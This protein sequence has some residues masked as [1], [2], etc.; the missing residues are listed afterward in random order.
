VVVQAP[1]D[2]P[3][4]ANMVFTALEQAVVAF[5]GGTSAVVDQAAQTWRYYRVDVPAGVLGWDLRLREVSG[6]MPQMVVRRDLLP[7]SVRTQGS[8]NWQRY[9]GYNT[10]WP[11]GYQ[12]AAGSD[13]TG[14]TY[15]TGA[16]DF[17]RPGPRMLMA[18]GTPLEA[19]TYYVG[20][21]NPSASEGSS[22]VLDSRGVGLAGSGYTYAVEAEELALN[23]GAVTVSGVAPREAR[24]YRLT[25]PEN[26]PSVELELEVTSGEMLMAIRRGGIPDFGIREDGAPSSAEGE[27]YGFE[28]WV[29]KVGSERY[30]MLPG[31]GQTSITAGEYYVAVVGEGESPAGSV[32]GTGT[33]SGV[34]RSNGPLVVEDLGVATPGGLAHLVDL[35]AGQLKLFRFSV[36]EQTDSLEVRRETI[37]GSPVM[38]VQEGLAIPYTYLVEY[39]AEGGSGGSSVDPIFTQ[40]APQAGVWTVVVQAPKDA[41]ASANM[42]FTQ[43]QDIS[44]NFSV[45]QN[46]NG[47]SESD[48]RQLVDGQYQV[49]RFEVP[50]DLNGEP[51]VGWMI[52]AETS[53]GA[54][55]LQIYQDPASPDFSVKVGGGHA[56]VAPPYFKAG[57]T[58]YVRVKAQG[59]TSYT[60]TS[61]AVRLERSVWEL[62]LQFNQVVG[63][64]GQLDSGEPLPDD[65]GVDLEADHWHF[66]AV[67]VP[68]G[69][70]GLLRTELIAISGNPNLYIREDGVP[71]PHHNS[72]GPQVFGE[73][74]VHRSL[75][76]NVTEYGNWVPIDGRS[77]HQLPPGRWYLGVH[78]TA[79]SNVRYRLIVSSG[80]VDDLTIDG[81]VLSNQILPDN[82]WRYYRVQLPQDAPE[83]WLVTFSQQVGD[84]V[85]YLR[86]TVPPGQTTY[87]GEGWE[88]YGRNDSKNTG[89]EAFGSVDAPGTTEYKT[90]P[91]RPGAVYY[92]G[93]R[94]RSS[95]TFSVSSSIGAATIGEFPVLDF[96]TGALDLNLPA[97]TSVVYR[98][99]VPMEATR[100]KWDFS[101]SGGLQL[102][103]EQGTLPG[104][105]GSQHWVSNPGDVG[106]NAALGASWPWVVGMD[107]YL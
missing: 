34:L 55:S 103:L 43:K 49:Y 82:D 45:E 2:A 14:R 53:Q 9:P 54:V 33:S 92:V 77:Q 67:D 70:L 83:S 31:R 8:A 1:K 38:L 66:Y 10:G 89:S 97:N 68:E 51:I 90:P 40:A 72:N 78:A 87:N 24:Y 86:D 73:A 47:G 60:L 56:V 58:W 22:Y 64:S 12:W 74:L 88:Q 52:D 100:L 105:T 17:R 94:S 101:H 59:L 80:R 85:M 21:Y 30:V 4:S 18:M 102:R 95:A 23:G 57:E 106:F 71:T 41:P 99:P 35:E 81:G 48:S 62:P 65:Q 15:D 37:S 91:L 19:G 28:V 75:T 104:L 44:L 20:V 50:E 46:G 29:S 61:S 7:E 63:D 84:V 93:F 6:A 3:A 69:N 96:Y 13:W 25:V 36:P 107:Y 79:A 5:D 16:P 76:G 98:I 27:Y 32:I 39:G 42:V 11:S 26:T